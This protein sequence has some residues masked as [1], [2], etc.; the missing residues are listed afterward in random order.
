MI[1]KAISTHAILQFYG[2]LIL[3]NHSIQ[4][5]WIQTSTGEG[6]TDTSV[7]TSAEN[8]AARIEAAKA[9]KRWLYIILIAV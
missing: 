6:E 9:E 4:I 3:C 5:I 7:I 8:I 1:S 2:S